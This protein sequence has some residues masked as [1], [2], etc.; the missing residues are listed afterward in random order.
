MRVEAPCTKDCEGRSATCHTT[1][2]RYLEWQKTHVEEIRKSNANEFKGVQA[3][4]YLIET[5][6]K[7]AK[8]R[9]G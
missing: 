3:K 1:C 2:E 9:N 4:A 8:R 5:A 6:L 7:R